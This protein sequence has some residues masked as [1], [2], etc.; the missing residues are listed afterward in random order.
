MQIGKL[1]YLKF[2]NFFK[3]LLIF[4]DI[5]ILFYSVLDSYF[6]LL[7]IIDE[8]ESSTVSSQVLIKLLIKKPGIKDNNVQIQKL[9]LECLKKVIEKFSITRYFV[10]VEHLKIIF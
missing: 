3:Y 1:V 4:S 5:F 2:K 9:K 8:I 7:Q 6:Q 10:T